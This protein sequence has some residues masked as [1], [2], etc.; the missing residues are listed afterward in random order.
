VIE[1]AKKLTEDSTLPR[2]P[3]VNKRNVSL[4]GGKEVTHDD[5]PHNPPEGSI[6]I[7]GFERS[8]EE[9]SEIGASFVKIE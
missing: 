2:I 4:N 1:E 6:L 5:G 7:T 9:L 3:K 8:I